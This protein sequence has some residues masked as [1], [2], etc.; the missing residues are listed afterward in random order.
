MRTLHKLLLGG[1]LAALL[2]T[3]YASATWVYDYNTA[4][5]ADCV[6]VACTVTVYNYVYSDSD[7]GDCAGTPGAYT[8]C[9]VYQECDAYVNGLFPAGSVTCSS[10]GSGT[11]GGNP[12]ACSAHANGVAI[13]AR[14]TCMDFYATGSVVTA[15]GSATA[16][17]ANIRICVNGNGPYQ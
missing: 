10:G 1:V 14:G 16:V 7:F 13:V 5:A 2:A 8:S 12:T 4:G 15:T 17:T 3:P 11:C 9:I 6:G